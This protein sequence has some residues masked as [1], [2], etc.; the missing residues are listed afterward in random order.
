MVNG[1]PVYV[2]VRV[3]VT[4]SRQLKA[5]Q[6]IPCG[7]R[8]RGRLFTSLLPLAFPA[9]RRFWSFLSQSVQDSILMSCKTRV[10][11]TARCHWNGVD[12]HTQVESASTARCH[13]NGYG[14]QDRAK[15]GERTSASTESSA[16]AMCV[17][18]MLAKSPFLTFAIPP[19]SSHVLSRND[20]ASCDSR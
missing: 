20:P 17:R 1:R 5:T 12:R 3:L 11:V 2:R 6:A 4:C 8:V 19:N 18:I 15:C 7:V 13:W 16:S 10:C 14:R 9:C